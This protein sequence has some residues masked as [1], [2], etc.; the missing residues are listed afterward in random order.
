MR[1][2]ILGLAVT[3]D[4]FIE[5]PKGEY[6]WCFTDQDYGMKDFL[7]RID[8]IFYGRKSYELMMKAGGNPFQKIRS[9]VFSNSW[10]AKEGFDLVSGEI[11]REV[12]KIKELPGKDIWLFGGASLTSSLMNS[13]LVDEI[14]LS[15]HPVLL[16]AG[17][18]LFTE[19]KERTSLQLIEEKAYE[20]GLVSLRY[21]VRR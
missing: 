1:K 15:V 6:N 11:T 16:G 8:A 2:I 21:S 20:T 18:R 14:W 5:G 13:R 19:I 12:E 10:D 3:L 4:G 9:Y 17:K 7:S